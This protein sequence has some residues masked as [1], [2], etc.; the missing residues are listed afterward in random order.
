M[1]T[2]SEKLKIAWKQG[3]PWGLFMFFLL[4]VILPWRKGALSLSSLLA[5]VVFWS[6]GSL[7]IGLWLSFILQRRKR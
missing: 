7:L 2:R 5:G 3:W 4:E 6:I 1:P